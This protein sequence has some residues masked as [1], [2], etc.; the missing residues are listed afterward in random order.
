MVRET[1]PPTGAEGFKK[2]PVHPDLFRRLYH[3]AIDNDANLW[4]QA[5]NVLCAALGREDLKIPLPDKVVAR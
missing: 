3:D 2:I 4:Q 5:H 1:N